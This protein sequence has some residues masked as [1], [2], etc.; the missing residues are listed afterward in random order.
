M[1]PAQA[2]PAGARAAAFAGPGRLQQ[3]RGTAIARPGDGRLPAG[4][5]GQEVTLQGFN[6]Q[7]NLNVFIQAGGVT[8][9]NQ[10]T[11]DQGRFTTNLFM[12]VT[13]TGAQTIRVLDESGNV[14]TAPFFTEF[15]FG[16]LAKGQ[17]A[18]AEQ[19]SAQGPGTGIVGID[20]GDNATEWWVI[21]LATLGG[22]FIAAIA[23]SALT[24]LILTRRRSSW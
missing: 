13:G 22:A 23:A 6:L 17:D 8:I 9:A 12:P 21:F 14:A 16:D 2:I 4:P 10:R 20:G 18:I 15:G 19:L 7:P 1:E 24:V 5:G 3:Q 11:D